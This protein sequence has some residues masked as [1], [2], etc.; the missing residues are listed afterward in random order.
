MF[1][2]GS[3][4]WGKKG[5]RV[6]EMPVEIGRSGTGSVS[7]SGHSGRV[8]PRFL[9]RPF[10]LV[11]RYLADGAEAPRFAAT[12]ITAGFLGS[13]AL[14]GAVLGGH[15][16]AVVQAVTAHTG[17]AI[18]EIKISGHRETSEIDILGELELNG[19][20]S[21]IGFSVDDAREKIAG[22]PWVET[23]SIR[24]SYPSALEINIAEREPFA[25][26]Q[27][28]SS[29]SLVEKSG[30]VI[31]GFSGGKYGTLPLV[32]GFGAPQRAAGIIAQTAN[33]PKLAARVKAFIRVS[34]R[35]WDLRLRNGITIKLPARGQ[36]Q[37]MADLVAM[38][39]ASGILSR[40]IKTVDMRLADR[41]IVGLSSE[42]V[43]QRATMLK[44]REE[45]RRQE[46]QT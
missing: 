36:V 9:R 14:Y 3:K 42:A 7:S 40:D 25:I 44:E 19:W 27:S 15:M 10:R 32:V 26:W 1:A 30:D 22:L 24:K 46:Q 20:T 4:F 35:R 6:T 34:D 29:L 12:V 5:R 13:V 38:D 41:L 33:T 28:G 37:A 8:L 45:R 11:S 31:T 21:L 2:L 23:V 18:E 39:R 16:P 43:K 17:F